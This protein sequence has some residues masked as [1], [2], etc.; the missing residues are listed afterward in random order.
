MQRDLKMVRAPAKTCPNLSRLFD[1]AGQGIALW[2][3][4][5]APEV[6]AGTL[7]PLTD[8]Q[9]EGAGYHVVFPG[10]VLS[11]GACSMLSWLKEQVRG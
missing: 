7:V 3:D 4:L 9:L 8:T 11:P 10:R 2:D 1:D 5:V 6:E